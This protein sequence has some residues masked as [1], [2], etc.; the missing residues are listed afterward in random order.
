MP[1]DAG[2]RNCKRCGK[3]LTARQKRFCSSYCVGKVY[4]KKAGE[5]NGKRI[6]GTGRYPYIRARHNGKLDYLHRVVWEK[7]NG[8]RLE[9]GEVVHHINGDKRDNRPENLEV[10]RDQGEHCRRHFHARPDVD[11]SYDPDIGF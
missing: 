5:A 3:A 6:R 8:R 2:T 4:A 1:F 9:P 7:A 10:V 11:R